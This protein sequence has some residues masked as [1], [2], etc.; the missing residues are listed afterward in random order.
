MDE[1]LLLQLERL[2]QAAESLLELGRRGAGGLCQLLLRPLQ[3]PQQR[4][5]AGGSL[6]LAVGKVVGDGFPGLLQR[7]AGM[8]QQAA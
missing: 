6:C 1:K 2:S 3:V 7:L 8:R 4:L 5:Q